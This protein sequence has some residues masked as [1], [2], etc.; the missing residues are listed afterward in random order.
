MRATHLILVASV[1]LAVVC[2][3]AGV[4]AVAQPPKSDPPGAGVAALS[5]DD[6]KAVRQVI[7]G[8]EEAWNA[9]DMK[10][11]A[12]LLRDDVEWVNIVG[13]HWKGK[14][15]VVA[16]HEAFHKTMFKD[17]RMATD[18]VE[19]RPL[20]GGHVI[21]VVTT[22]ND[23]FTTPGGQVMPKAQ[24]RQTYVL[25]KEPGGW[26]IAHC[27]NVRVDAEAARNDPVNSEKK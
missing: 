9:H 6:E 18:A 4:G 3:T 12:K 19:L 13:M 23:A 17:H 20:G 24:N 21:A 14:D 1:L 10:A 16:A 15:A 5:A 8:F 2:L 22:T 26:R 11:F 7:R 27:Q 25:T